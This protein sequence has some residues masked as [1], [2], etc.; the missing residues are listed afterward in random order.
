MSAAAAFQDLLNRMRHARPS[1]ALDR[2]IH[3]IAVGGWAILAPRYTSDFE[4]AYALLRTT[5]VTMLELRG[6]WEPLSP[7]VHAAWTVEY[8]PRD[9]PPTAGDK[10][11]WH[12]VVAGGVAPAIALCRAALTVL[13]RSQGLTVRPE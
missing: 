9:R 11:G 2:E 5:D 8:Y 6:S 10:G 12:A 7:N 3:R 4:A 13:A 1:R